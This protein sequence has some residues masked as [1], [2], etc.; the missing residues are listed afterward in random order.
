MTITV[1]IEEDQRIQVSNQV[2]E[3][4]P[5]AQ[6]EFAAEGVISMTEGLLSEFGGS[7]LRPLELEIAVDS[8]RTVTVD[9][10]EQASLWL[11]TVDVG[12][13]TPDMDELSPGMETISSS[14]DTKSPASDAHAGSIAF[15]IEGAI[16]DV[17]EKTRE[18]LTDASP[19]LESITLAVEDS[20][21]SDGGS[22]FDV[23]LEIDLLGYAI[24]IHQDGTIDIGLNGV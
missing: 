6:I 20:V 1:T 13:E 11:D 15:T 12:V 2:I 5:P 8:S 22:S 18:L 17:P 24:A 16:T 10:S 21:R 4:A 23:I 19:E 3:T 14:T 7:S 9:L